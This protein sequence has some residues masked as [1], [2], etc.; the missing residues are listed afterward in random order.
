MCGIFAVL[1]NKH[2]ELENVKEQFNKGKNRGPEYSKLENLQSINSYIGFH[3]LAINGVDD[4]HSNQP[5]FI[6]NIYLVC[7]G[8]I[9]NHKELFNT[10]NI[11]PRSKSDCE[12]IIHLYKKYGIEQTVQMLDGVF[13]FVLIDTNN[14]HIYV[15]RDTYGVRP[16]L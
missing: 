6:D 3:R 11:T 4:T 15:A 5:F 16:Y 8:E 2:L 7:N 9:Y 13:A 12:I 10:L 1:N 14:K